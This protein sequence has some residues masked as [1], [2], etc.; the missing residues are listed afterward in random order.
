M[1]DSGRVD[2]IALVQFNHIAMRIAH[3]DTLR[4]GPEADRTMA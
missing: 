2:S 3:A 1:P 4:A